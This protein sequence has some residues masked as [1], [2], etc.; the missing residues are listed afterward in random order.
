[1]VSGFF[2]EPDGTSFSQAAAAAE[3][4][5]RPKKGFL[6]HG[7]AQ[8]SAPRRGVAKHSPGFQGGAGPW[9]ALPTGTQ[10]LLCL[11]LMR[12]RC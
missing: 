10:A 5:R 6:G 11:S 3:A 2:V 12:C 9:R 4:L 1:M 8:G 7:S